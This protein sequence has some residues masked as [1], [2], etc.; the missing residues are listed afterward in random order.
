MSTVAARRRGGV[1]GYV[2][3]AI[4]TVGALAAI[5]SL[6]SLRTTLLREDGS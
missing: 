5:P 4:V 2:L 1:I 3:A 6:R